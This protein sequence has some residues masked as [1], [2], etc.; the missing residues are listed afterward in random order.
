MNADHTGKIVRKIRGHQRRQ[1]KVKVKV[2]RAGVGWLVYLN[3]NL[4]VFFAPF[5]TLR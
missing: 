3:L 4:P 2:K 1:G 5:A